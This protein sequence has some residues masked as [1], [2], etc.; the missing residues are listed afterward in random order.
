MPDLNR[1]QQLDKEYHEDLCNLVAWGKHYRDTELAKLE[2]KACDQAAEKMITTLYGPYIDE[3]KEPDAETLKAYV[4]I[5]KRF[6]ATCEKHKLTALPPKASSIAFFLD[7]LIDEGEPPPALLGAL[8]A[9][10]YYARLNEAYDPTSDPMVTAIIKAASGGRP[11]TETVN[12][13]AN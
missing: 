11:N 4:E 12:R 1:E 5:C 7:A 8:R 13:E 10:S 6:M 3:R 9:L 2:T